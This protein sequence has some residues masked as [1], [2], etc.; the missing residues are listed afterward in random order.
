MTSGQKSL[1]AL[2]A[3]VGALACAGVGL[4]YHGAHGRSSQLFGPSIFRGPGQR[5]SIALTFDDGPNAQTLDLLEFLD[6]QNIRATFFQCGLNA[7]R[8]PEI[9]AQVHA[10]GHEIGNHTWSHARLC[11]RLGWQPNFRSAANIY[12]ELASTQGLLKQITGETPRLFRPPYGMRWLGLRE[13]QLRLGLLGVLWTVIGHDWEWPA[14]RIAE[15]VLA[16]ASPGGIICLHDGRD[17]QQN[18]NLTEML[19]ALKIIVPALRDAG[20][21]FEAVGDLLAPDRSAM[22]APIPQGA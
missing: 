10:A 20:Y 8:R 17:I 18:V 14:D 4:L 2:G 21:E 15:F 7:R 9:T 12:S 5:R 3:G 16:G 22:Q 11:P 13:A 6:A 19:A 1:A